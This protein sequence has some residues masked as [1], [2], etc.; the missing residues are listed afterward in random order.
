MTQTNNLP[1]SVKGIYLRWRG[2]STSMLRTVGLQFCATKCYITARSG[3]TSTFSDRRVNNCGHG[4]IQQLFSAKSRIVH[5][6]W[7]SGIV[8]CLNRGGT[9]WILGSTVQRWGP[10]H[11]L[12]RLTQQTL[13]PERWV[14][15][16]G[17]RS[18]WG[19]YAGLASG[20]F[21]V[22]SNMSTLWKRLK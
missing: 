15:V 7:A 18:R 19:Q 13:W 12:V 9:N 11:C 1:L 2:K 3:V 20:A 10:W 17:V 4:N 6:G 14:D 21:L 16:K 8:K 5:Y 22:R